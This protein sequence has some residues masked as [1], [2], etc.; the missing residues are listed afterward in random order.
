MG[1]FIR[2]TIDPEKCVGPE[3]SGA[4]VAICPV[5]IFEARGDWVAV[6]EENEDECTLCNLCIDKCPT[7]AFSI[8][9]LYG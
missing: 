1:V 4:C 3:K 7:S 5:N 9:K 2:V 6:Q 8:R